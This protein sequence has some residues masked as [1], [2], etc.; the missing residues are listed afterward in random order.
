[1]RRHQAPG[2][3]REFICAFDVA[4][5]GE[6]PHGPFGRAKHTRTLC[7]PTVDVVDRTVDEGSRLRGLASSSPDP[8]NAARLVNCVGPDACLYLH[9]ENGGVNA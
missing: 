3:D 2:E 6:K 9:L 5:D 4:H 7:E 1:M 8:A